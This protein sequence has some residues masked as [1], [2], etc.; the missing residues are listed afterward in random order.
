MN[1]MLVFGYGYS[2]RVIGRAL[3]DD[4]WQV[5]GTTRTASGRA[6]ITASGAD[7]LVFGGTTSSSQLEAALA[8]A[9]HILVSIPPDA[10]GDPVLRCFRDKLV[11][12]SR[13]AWLGYLSTVG[14]YGDHEGG[15]VDEKTSPKPVSE[16]S[17]RRLT[18]EQAWQ[19]L[20]AETGLALQIFRLAGI[21]GPG[22]SAIDRLRAGTAR[23]LVKPDQVFNRIHVDDIAGAV[24]AGIAHP[25]VTGII[26]VADDEP[27]PPQDVIT[28]GA[29]LLGIPPPPEQDFATADLTPMARSFYGEN[30]RVSNRRLRQEL[31]YALRYPTFRDGLSA[32]L[33]RN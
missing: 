7:A 29:E 3:L 1:C 6:S 19:A 15:W 16:R 13:L 27:A 8:A 4:G 21:Y 5:I 9:S 17:R 23:R 20:A 14:V 28:Y 25:D 2:A 22:R 31:D 18:A 10:A 11:E 33:G 30:K 12:R 24:L 32:L 26:N